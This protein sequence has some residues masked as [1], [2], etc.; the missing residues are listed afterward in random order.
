MVGTSSADLDL[1]IAM[2]DYQSKNANGAVTAAIFSRLAIT[3]SVAKNQQMLHEREVKG[4]EYLWIEIG[5][6]MIWLVVWNIF[7]HNIWDNPSHWLIFFKMVETTNQ[8]WLGSPEKWTCS[9]K[10][11]PFH[12]KH[13]TVQWLEARVCAAH[14][15][16]RAGWCL[17]PVGPGSWPPKMGCFSKQKNCANRVFTVIGWVAFG[18]FG[19]V[20]ADMDP[21]GLLLHCCMVDQ[22]RWI[23]WPLAA[24]SNDEW[25]TRPA[26]S[27]DPKRNG[28]F[29]QLKV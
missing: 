16:L 18:A 14:Y 17:D 27:I 19:C 23:N 28:V 22:K 9:W 6:I 20:W 7:F 4:Y 2:F 13:V 29:C 5:I 15:P 1:F 10:I 21:Y 8:W 11:L 12:E 3:K 24:R 26:P 25:Y